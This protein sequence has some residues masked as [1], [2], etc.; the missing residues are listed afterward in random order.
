MSWMAWWPFTWVCL[1][2]VEKPTSTFSFAESP[3]K[4]HSHLD[5]VG[6]F[7]TDSGGRAIS[8]PRQGTCDIFVSPSCICPP[9]FNQNPLK[10]VWLHHMTY[11][12]A[13][14]SSHKANQKEIGNQQAMLKNFRKGIYNLF[15]QE[16][17]ATLSGPGFYWEVWVGPQCTPQNNSTFQP[18]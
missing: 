11:S 8:V 14:S 2:F 16:D 9:C 12:F 10:L 17:M 5:L 3:I 4:R 13:R 15:Y 18:A 1:F 7:G 6:S